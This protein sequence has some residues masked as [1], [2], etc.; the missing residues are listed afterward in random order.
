LGIIGLSFS[1][2]LLLFLN[3]PVIVAVSLG[4]TMF[5]ILHFIY[6]LGQEIRFLE[7]GVILMVFYYLLAPY[8][9]YYYFDN[10]LG[11]GAMYNSAES[12]YM[13]ALFCILA[14]LLG[15][16]INASKRIFSTTVIHKIREHSDKNTTIG[17]QFIII[18]IVSYYINSYVPLAFSNILYL[19]GTLRF[20][21]IF[22]ILLSNHKKKYLIIILSS[23]DFVLNVIGG[24][25]FFE[26]LIW[27]A[28][29]FVFY[30]S[31]NY[32]TF[33]KKLL[34]FA[35]SW[36]FLFSLQ[37]AKTEYREIVW[38][39]QSNSETSAIG[40]YWSITAR[41]FS[42]EVDLLN[43]SNFE[44][45]IGRINLGWVVSKTMNHV[46]ENDLFTHGETLKEDIP[47]ILF[48]RFLYPEKRSIS[49]KDLRDRFEHF[50]G[51]KLQPGTTINLSALGDA[52]IN[53]GQTGG[54]VAMFILGWM[55][56]SLLV[57]FKKASDRYPSIVLWIPIIYFNLIRM[58]DF[59]VL[60]NT[61]VKNSIFVIL[62]FYI[63]HK[64][65]L[66]K[67]DNHIVSSSPEV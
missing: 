52:F 32:V 15:S 11:F 47:S 53:F 50:T 65:L 66:Y 9:A 31:I 26:L 13:Y 21:G 38:G 25:V 64:Q 56:S 60:L 63:F 24:S 37:I 48:P 4:F 40:L 51:R 17:I 62:V 22:Y 57:I 1:L 10:E 7:I 5:Y 34:F 41:Q 12:Y 2:I 49:G 8:F 33:R 43:K 61:L 20:V 36:V 46:T 3:R 6:F 55:F 44:R 18:G 30:L 35:I 39:K 23:I 19:A 54:W 59:Y 14:F 28:F 67:T 27:G 16:R 58:N 45:F 29:F 42:D